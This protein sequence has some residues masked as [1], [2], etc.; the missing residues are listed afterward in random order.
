MVLKPLEKAIK[1][2]DPIRALVSG[3][4]IGQDGRTKGITMPNGI[5]QAD[6]IKS[7]YNDFNLDPARTGY[8]EAH[9]T[10]TAAGDPIEAAALHEVFGVDR[11]HSEPLF[12]GSIK[13]NI[14]HL[15]G[16]SGVISVIKTAMMLQ[17]GWILP[18]YDFKAP[19]EKIPLKQWN[20]Q[21]R[22]VPVSG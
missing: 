8:V 2:N 3:T 12:V 18:N 9:G 1:A 13:S 14:G 20:L 4:G 6:L 17:R 10:G 11:S 15:E 7:V 21:V 16:A 22:R 19:N 5:A